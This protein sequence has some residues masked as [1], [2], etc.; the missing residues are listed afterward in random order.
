[1]IID[2]LGSLLQRLFVPEENYFSSKIDTLKTDLNNKIP[3]QQYS[4]TLQSIG[5]AGGSNQQAISSSIDLNNYKLTDRFT[6]S[7]SNFIDFSIFSQYRDTWFVWVRVVVY[8][9][10]FLYNINEI[11][12]FLRGFSVAGYS[13]SHVNQ[14]NISGGD[15]K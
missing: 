7:M 13:S 5:Q 8:A 4:N 1:M 3:Y 11:T 6:L 15:S 2:L 9:L 12:K 14:N 10:L